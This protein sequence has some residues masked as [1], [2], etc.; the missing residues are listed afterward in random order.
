MRSRSFFQRQAELT[1]TGRAESA[2]NECP[3]RGERSEIEIRQGGEE[4]SKG[5]GEGKAGLVGSWPEGDD[6][7]G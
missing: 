3:G 1:G 5:E 6:G 4:G 7:L 2:V